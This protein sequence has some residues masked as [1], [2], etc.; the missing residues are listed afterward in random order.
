MSRDFIGS[1]QGR[2]FLKSP[3]RDRVTRGITTSSYFGII[4]QAFRSP[5]TPPNASLLESPS[6]PAPTF[7]FQNINE[8]FQSTEAPNG[9]TPLDVFPDILGLT[10]GPGRFFRIVF[11]VYGISELYHPAQSVAAVPF[12]TNPTFNDVAVAITIPNAFYLSFGDKEFPPMVDSYVASEY[13]RNTEEP[14]TPN[15]TGRF[16]TLLLNHSPEAVEGIYHWGKRIT[17]TAK[18]TS[19][20][21]MNAPIS[22]TAPIRKQIKSRTNRQNPPPQYNYSAQKRYLLRNKKDGVAFNA[23]HPFASGR[24][25]IPANLVEFPALTFDPELCNSVYGRMTAIEEVTAHAV[26]TWENLFEPVKV[27][28]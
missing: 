5:Q 8:R 1:A 25:L 18:T 24:T 14:D 16:N 7:L 17:V 23:V 6:L 12:I 10:T 22:L 3:N 15:L 9:T 28:T 2:S 4:I 21:P 19:I 26:T 27:S 11:E 13:W 20:S